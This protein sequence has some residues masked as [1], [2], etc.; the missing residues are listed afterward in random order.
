MHGIPKL[1]MQTWKTK[2][3]PDR[4]KSSPASIRTF[5][6]DWSYVL[7]TDLDNENF[8]NHFFPHLFEWYRGL[9]YNIQR[10]D[11]IRYLWLYEHGGLYLDLDIEL[12]GSLDELFVGAMDTWLLKAPRNFAGHYTNFMMASTPKNPFWLK[13]IE[14]CLKPLEFWVLLPHHI[15]SQQTGLA[16]ITRAASAWPK[17]IALLPQV[18]LVPCDYCTP[19]NCAKPFSYTRFLEGQSWNGID[20]YA[21]NFVCCNPELLVLI[22]VGLLAAYA[23]TKRRNA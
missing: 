23:L 10:A 16:A 18:S 3:V 9:R 8:V 19:H 11:V 1:V 20:T 17:P 12:V 5:L 22:L 4:W 6:P 7:L 21:I 15:I 13:V 14:E 2:T